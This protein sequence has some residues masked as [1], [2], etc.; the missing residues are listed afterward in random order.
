MVAVRNP[1]RA[2]SPQETAQPRNALAERNI[3]PAYSENREFGRAEMRVGLGSSAVAIKIRGMA[4]I[5]K[6]PHCRSG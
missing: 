1:L 5:E 6:P 4:T 3:E 2:V